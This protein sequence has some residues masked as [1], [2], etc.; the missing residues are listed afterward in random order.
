MRAVRNQ[1][2]AAVV[3]AQF[4]RVERHLP[5]STRGDCG[6]DFART[7][8]PMSILDQHA[9]LAVQPGRARIEVV[10]AYEKRLPS[11]TSALVC[12]LAPRI[13]TYS[14]RLVARQG[15]Q[16][17]HLHAAFEQR[18]SMSRVAAMHR[19]HVIRR[20]R[21][22]QHTHRLPGLARAISTSLFIAGNEVR[23]DDLQSSTGA[24]A[25]Q[26]PR[27]HHG[28]CTASFVCM[29]TLAGSSDTKRYLDDHCSAQS[30]AT[31]R[32]IRVVGTKRQRR[33]RS[34]PFRRALAQPCAQ[35]VERRFSDGLLIQQFQRPGGR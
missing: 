8:P 23:R 24:A 13:R 33:T 5:G 16:L 32:R 3:P 22:G 4:A 27:G 30:P 19:G 28:A 12:R 34:A 25:P 14:N 35:R 21:I 18:L 11:A 2:L 29:V 6:E 9:L 15:F 1:G 10:A 7:A 26:R 31:S 20:Q 17:P